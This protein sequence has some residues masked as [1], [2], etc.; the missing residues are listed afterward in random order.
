MSTFGKTT[1]G[2]SGTLPVGNGNQNNTLQ[3][4]FQ[5]VEAALV[6]DI[7]V[8]LAHG[9]GGSETFNIQVFISSDAGGV[10]GTQLAVATAS[11]TVSAPGWYTIPLSVTLAAGTYW[12]GIF[13]STSV[14]SGGVN[15][16]YDLDGGNTY[17]KGAYSAGVYTPGQQSARTFSF[18]ADYTPPSTTYN[19]SASDTGASISDSIVVHKILPRALAD[20]GNSFSETL[21]KRQ[22]LVDIG[23]SFSDTL[24]RSKVARPLADTGI[25]FSESILRQKGYLRTM[26]DVG[27][28]S[29]DAVVFGSGRVKFFFEVGATITDTLST[30][31]SATVP[32][33]PPPKVQADATEKLEAML[34]DLQ[35]EL[36]ED[37]AV[38][39]TLRAVAIELQRLDNAAD[40]VRRGFWPLWSDDTYGVLGLFEQL[41]ELPVEPVGLTLEQRRALIVAHFQKRLA[42]AGSDW[43]LALT[44]AMG[45][46]EFTY[47][48][49][50]APYTITIRYAFANG[51]P[52]SA[53]V[54]KLA[55]QMTPAHLQLVAGY[56]QGWLVGI[57]LIGDPL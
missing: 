19:R 32:P 25:T 30:L 14:G 57:S 34:G 2:A 47:I 27:V 18:F 55:R 6:S 22:Q 23:V 46:T 5:L 16:Y 33:P 45:S 43:E 40:G 15:A 38:I 50:P 24:V 12:I 49:G 29:A 20:T 36:L 10:P 8:Y 44:Q 41:F 53:Q 13:M 3:S 48:E 17:Y 9:S 52:N 21:R 37:P 1:V 56:S 28:T 51:A 4:Q 54:Q 31:F 39:A 7:Q 35:P 26:S 11:R 42:G